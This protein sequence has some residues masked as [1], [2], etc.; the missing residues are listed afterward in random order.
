MTTRFAGEADAKHYGWVGWRIGQL[1]HSG[2]ILSFHVPDV[3]WPFGLDL[4]LLDG[5]GPSLVA[6]R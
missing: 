2:H 6:G 5:V 4:R 1:I 3:L